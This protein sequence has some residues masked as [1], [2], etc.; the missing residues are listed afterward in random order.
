MDTTNQVKAIHAL[1]SQAGIMQ[2]KY[3]IIAAYGVE[4]TK[5]LTPEQCSDLIGRLKQILKARIAPSYIVKRWRS[6]VLAQLNRC[7]VYVTNNDWSRVNA[8]LLNPK[9]SGKLLYEMDEQEL[10]TLNRKLRSIAK[11]A[12]EKRARELMFHTTKN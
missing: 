2:S 9:I 12:E 11:K 5:D 8:F 4:S 6:N 7:G 3:E 10:K 1:L